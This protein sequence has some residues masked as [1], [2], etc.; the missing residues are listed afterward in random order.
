MV[1]MES[2]FSG[3][4]ASVAAAVR[5]GTP[6]ATPGPQRVV[7]GGGGGRARGT[8]RKPRGGG[9]RAVVVGWCPRRG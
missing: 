5:D 6:T 3:C 7:Q 9:E 8:G 2:P 4:R 1:D